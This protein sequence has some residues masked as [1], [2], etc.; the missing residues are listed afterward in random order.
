[1]P[2]FSDVLAQLGFELQ[3]QIWDA[4][5]FL[6]QHRTRAIILLRN[7]AK[8]IQNLRLCKQI[9]FAKRPR[10][11][12]LGMPWVM[13]DGVMDFLQVPEDIFRNPP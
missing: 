6:P 7:L 13:P 10:L 2:A 1:M 11:C 4:S 5:E 9:S 8:Q 3:F 12:D